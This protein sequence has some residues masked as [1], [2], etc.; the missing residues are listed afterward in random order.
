MS[1]GV[2][3]GDMVVG[4]VLGNRVRARLIPE[5]TPTGRVRDALLV[6]GSIEARPGGGS[7]I[8]VA[9]DA[10]RVFERATSLGLA[11]LFVAFIVGHIAV[12]WSGFL[13]AAG[14]CVIFR[15]LRPARGRNSRSE[16]EPPGSPMT[17]LECGN[18]STGPSEARLWTAL[19]IAL[20]SCSGPRRPQLGLSGDSGPARIRTGSVAV[21]PPRSVSCACSSFT[22]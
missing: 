21:P 10:P 1:V 12:G 22:P 18:G 8:Y 16:P 6:R 14:F 15:G 19:S 7:R 20:R 17:L 4:S 13:F 11:M 5:D 9:V 2:R 3:T